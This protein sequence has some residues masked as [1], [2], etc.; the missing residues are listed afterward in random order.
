M[1]ILLDKSVTEKKMIKKNL[2]DFYK[3]FIFGKEN[4]N[5]ANIN[6]FVP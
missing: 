1:R 2:V 5:Q 6:A 3:N 4:T